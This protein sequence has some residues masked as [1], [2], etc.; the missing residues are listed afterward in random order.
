MALLFIGRPGSKHVNHIDGNKQNNR[1][2]NLEYVTRAGNAEHAHRTVLINV[3]GEGNGRAVLT[4]KLVRKI[5]KLD[6]GA[7]VPRQK[8]SE[9]QI[10]S[11]E[12]ALLY[13]V[14]DISIM[15]IWKKVTW[16][17]LK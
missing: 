9:R 8:G 13:K 5:R 11:K 15:N 10:L 16:A 3:K 4:E 12:L 1:R 17:H 7:G 2:S 14:T 6:P